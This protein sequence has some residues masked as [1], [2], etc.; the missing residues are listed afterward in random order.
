MNAFGIDHQSTYTAI[1]LRE[2]AAEAVTRRIGDGRQLLIP[3]LV[4]EPGLWGAA[5]V[6]G[7]NPRPLYAQGSA[8]AAA[9]GHFWGGLTAHLTAYLGRLAPV[10]ENGYRVV[11][12]IGDGLDAGAVAS[13]ARR[14]GLHDLDVITPVEALRCRWLIAPGERPTRPQTVVAISCG[15]LTTT[16]EA[17]VIDL[18]SPGPPV[19]LARSA[20][21][22]IE[23]AGYA[24]WGQRLI[25][26][27]QESAI[28]PLGPDYV[29]NPAVRL[30]I[31]R[32]VS[33][34]ARERGTIE[35]DGGL[36]RRLFAPVRISF[37]DCQGW[38][39]VVAATL[40]LRMAVD[41]ELRSLS[42]SRADALLVGGIGSIWPFIADAARNLG[43]VW[44]SCDPSE[45]LASGAA[46][47]HQ[48][49]ARSEMPA[50][51][52][53]TSLSAPTKHLAAGEPVAIAEEPVADESDKP[54]RPPWIERREN[55]AFED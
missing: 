52:R 32:L 8:D 39:E 41:D 25:D 19:I 33:R 48:V 2:E 37:E 9:Q 4:A 38:P 10:Q 30:S 35:W 44:T 26:R 1:S 55:L 50:T 51:P 3:N 17:S 21:A 43:D 46:A 24:I 11:L 42:V 15:D 28:E 47:W 31:R 34:F 5:A 6:A 20:G 22:R 27:L 18:A 36:P 49:R 40:R 54:L 45:D 29:W 23:A 12:S 14:A 13:A 16:L 53:A 7:V